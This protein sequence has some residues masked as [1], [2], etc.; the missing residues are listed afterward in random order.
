MTWL[1][2]LPVHGHYT[3]SILPALLIMP[4]GY[5][6]SFPSIYAAATSGVAPWLAGITSGLISASQQMGGAV[7]LAVVSGIAASVTD[8][9]TRHS[10][11]S[12]LTS[13]YHA[14][15]WGAVALNVIALVVA[16]AVIRRPRP[17]VAAPE[18]QSPA[19]PHPHGA[20][21]N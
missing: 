21:A 15:L 12:A 9:R 17:D 3:S 19:R 5:G 6:M 8:S 10:H 14:G 13:G 1:C 4:L 2:F 11:D 20:V 16:S 7:G 18:R